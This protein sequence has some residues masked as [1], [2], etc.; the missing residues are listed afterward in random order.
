MATYTS[1]NHLIDFLVKIQILNRRVK[2]QN[3]MDLKVTYFQKMADYNTTI[4][5]LS[6]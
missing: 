5:V 6:K 3:R 4:I 1:N 2:A